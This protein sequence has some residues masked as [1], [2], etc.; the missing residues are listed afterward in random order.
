MTNQGILN[1]MCTNLYNKPASLQISV[2]ILDQIQYNRI[3]NIIIHGL[4]IQYRT[5]E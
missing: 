4:F 5:R 2:K 1:I 3:L